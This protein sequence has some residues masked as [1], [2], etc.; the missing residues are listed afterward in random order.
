MVAHWGFNINWILNG[1]P[2][3]MAWNCSLTDKTVNNKAKSAS[4][5]TPC[6]RK[7]NG[8]AWQEIVRAK[9]IKQKRVREKRYDHFENGSDNAALGQVNEPVVWRISRVR[10]THTRHLSAAN[11]RN[12]LKHNTENENKKKKKKK[13]KNTAIEQTIGWLCSARCTLHGKLWKWVNLLCESDILYISILAR[14]P[15]TSMCLFFL[16]SPSLRSQCILFLVSKRLNQRLS[17]SR[18]SF[19]Q[20]RRRFNITRHERSILLHFA[21]AMACTRTET[22]LHEAAT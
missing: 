19:D 2:N 9:P 17:L 12:P 16:L 3:K 13:N 8:F 1:N 22:R 7:R 11:H 14:H 21:I 10:D 18:L 4:I 5:V 20:R 15:H 6:V